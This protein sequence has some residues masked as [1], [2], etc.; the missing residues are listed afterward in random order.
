[1]NLFSQFQLVYQDSTYLMFQV[2]KANHQTQ[3]KGAPKKRGKGQRAAPRARISYVVPSEMIPNQAEE[4]DEDEEDLDVI[5]ASQYF[6]SASDSDWNS[7]SS[8]FDEFS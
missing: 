7:S 4:D 8:R 6:S 3:N 2:S 5:D 1:M